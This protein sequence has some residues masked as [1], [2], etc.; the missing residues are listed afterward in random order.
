MGEKK[1]GRPTDNPKNIVLKIRLD[2]DSSKRLEECSMNMKISKAE[3]IR[4]GIK[5]MYDGQEK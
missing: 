5:M 4:R 3:V 2:E 1:L